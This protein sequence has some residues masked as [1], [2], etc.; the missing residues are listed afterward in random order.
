MMRQVSFG[1]AAMAGLWCAGVRAVSAQSAVV[2]PVAGAP[3]GPLMAAPAPV[4]VPAPPAVQLAPEE[5]PEPKVDDEAMRA[6]MEAQRATLAAQRPE[7]EAQMKAFAAQAPAWAAETRAMLAAQR[8]EM[9]AQMKALLAEA[10]AMAAETRAAMTDMQA[11]LRPEVLRGLL[12]GSPMLHGAPLGPGQDAGGGRRSG[13]RAEAS[14]KDDLFAGTEKFAKNAKEATEVNMTPDDLEEVRGP[15]AM[16]ARETVL[17]VVHSYEFERPGMFSMA[18]VDEF[19]RKLDGPGWHCSV[20]TRDLKS[21][22]ST[23]VC[24]KRRTDGLRESAVITVE[25]KE[26]TFIHRVERVND[27]EHDSD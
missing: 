6:M 7:I 12:P 17:N 19:R 10:P 18:D 16:R 1:V 2:M 3:A 20:R 13:S 26:L 24:S 27:A 8:P 15:H 5:L 9:Q 14:V 23:D 22:G 4:G 21:G 11:S 25:P